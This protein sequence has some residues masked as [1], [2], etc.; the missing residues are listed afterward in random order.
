MNWLLGGTKAVDTVV[1]AEARPTFDEKRFFEKYRDRKIK[2]TEKVEKNFI[3]IIFNQIP[4]AAAI[5]NFS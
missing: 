2:G 3:S 1:K 5:E 4:I